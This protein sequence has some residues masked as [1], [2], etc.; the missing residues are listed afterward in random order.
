MAPEELRMKTSSLKRVH[1]FPTRGTL[2]SRSHGSQAYSGSATETLEAGVD[3][4][5][6]KQ[7][8]HVIAL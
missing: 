8:R 2:G 7:L 6:E 3:H 4:D 1:A 5:S